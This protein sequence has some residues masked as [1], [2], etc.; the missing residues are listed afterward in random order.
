MRNNFL[1]YVDGGLELEGFLA[2]AFG[3]TNAKMD[4]LKFYQKVLEI[5]EKH[6]LNLKGQEKSPGTDQSTRT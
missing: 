3:D 1:R 5:V 4:L 2:E 6:I